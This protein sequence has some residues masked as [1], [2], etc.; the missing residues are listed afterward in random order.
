MRRHG[1]QSPP[2]HHVAT[3]R[4]G[5]KSR[6][7]VLL[8]L[9]CLAVDLACVVVGACRLVFEPRDLWAACR[10]TAGAVSGGLLVRP[11]GGG[12]TSP[13]TL[14]FHAALA[15]EL[16]TRVRRNEAPAAPAEY[17]GPA[18]RRQKA[19]PLPNG[20]REPRRAA[21][22][23]DDMLGGAAA[24]AV[25]TTRGALVGRDVG[26][27]DELPVGWAADLVDYDA[28]GIEAKHGALA[29]DLRE[30][31]SSA[32][33]GATGSF[34]YKDDESDEALSCIPKVYILGAPKAGTSDLWRVLTSHPRSMKASRKET[35]FLTR[36]EFGAPRD[37]YVDQGTRLSEFAQSH[38]A[39]ARKVA[40]ELHGG[41]RSDVAVVD[42]GPHTLWWST[43]R[44][45]GADTG[46]VPAPQLMFHMVPEAKL[47]VS[48]AEPAKRMYSDYWF[49]TAAGVAKMV[50]D[51]KRRKKGRGPPPEI[52]SADDFHGKALEDARAMEL[53]F[54]RHDAAGGGGKFKWDVRAVQR[55][56]YDMKHFAKNGRG[57]IAVSVY[58]AY[59]ARWL[60]AY[61]RDQ[62]LFTRL[63]DRSDAPSMRAEMTRVF[64][65]LDMDPSAM[66]GLDDAALG[67]H[68]NAA[69]SERPAMRDDTAQVLR[70]FFRPHNDRLADL[71]GDP[72]FAW[73]DVAVGGGTG[74]TAEDVLRAQ[75]SMRK[76]R[77]RHQAERA[78]P[79]DA[80]TTTKRDVPADISVLDLVTRSDHDGL[81]DALEAHG[82]ALIAE[83]KVS[84]G[85]ALAS[86]ALILD[87]PMVSLLLGP[88]GVSANATEGREAHG[89]SSLHVACMTGLWGDSMRDSFTFSL[90]GGDPH[91]IDG[92]IRRGGAVAGVKLLKERGTKST[93]GQ[94]HIRQAISNAVTAVVDA[95]LKHGADPS[96]F[97]TQGKT[98]AHYC[99]NSGFGDAIELLAK[100]GANLDLTEKQ[101]GATPLTQAALNGNARAV[102]ALLENGARPQVR[103]GHGHDLFDLA[104]GRGAP[105][106]IMLAE[107]DEPADDGAGRVTDLTEY[108]D[109]VLL[110]RRLSKLLGGLYRDRDGNAAKADGALAPAG[111]PEALPA[112]AAGGWNGPLRSSLSELLWGVGAAPRSDAAIEARLDHCDFDV[113]E[114]GDASIELVLDHLTRNK[115]VILRGVLEG[116]TGAKAT[117]TPSRL[118]EM[119]GEAKVTV[120][121]IPY[122]K[123]FSSVL[124]DSEMTLGEYVDMMEARNL[125]GGRYPWYVFRGHPTSKM[126]KKDVA[127]NVGWF[128]NPDD[129]PTPEVIYKTFENAAAYDTQRGRGGRGGP[130]GG[131]EKRDRM[132]EASESAQRKAW[133][134]R[135]TLKGDDDDAPLPDPA[136]RIWPFVNL[137]WALGV[138]GS[139]APQHF[140]NTA[141]NALVYGA[142]R[143]LVFPPAYSFM[144]NM[145]I[146]QWDETEREENEKGVGQ[147]PP[148]ECIQRAGDVAI[149]PELWG[150]GIIN[151]QDTIAV[152]TEV[153]ASLFR[154]PLPQA[155][156]LVKFHQKDKKGDGEGLRPGRDHHGGEEPPPRRPRQ[157]PEYDAPYEQGAKP[158][159][160]RPQFHPAPREDPYLRKPRGGGDPF[161]DRRKMMRDHQGA[162]EAAR[163][164]RGA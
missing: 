38:E 141:W 65:F 68:A 94:L 44:H 131:R 74:R 78:R 114:A 72:K 110:R 125:T 41:G 71:L 153:K 31:R 87:E 1:Q 99:A 22:G 86:A 77:E 127:H 75:D 36:G 58:S 138:E 97:D 147:P 102:V 133:E 136:A 122:A 159:R 20:F 123:K 16:A 19:R 47:L 82:P 88:G 132:A 6:L 32:K 73:P 85:D 35:R 60:E 130:K 69:A 12:N 152:A 13:A 103:D 5:R 163:A 4:S 105:L 50:N 33:P 43:Q 117:Y 23:A 96:A 29:R 90:L 53:C 118:K 63:E 34:C 3:A 164:M 155:F 84:A 48:L 109:P 156:K 116:W 57:R 89:K 11:G 111:A 101:H 39:T 10:L 28:A 51:P 154:A 126:P 9:V 145:Q 149:I 129:T 64:E 7:P 98:P 62:F 91:V 15:V 151:L 17:E 134:D 135:F 2:R 66:S 95:L 37:G 27:A 92:A 21:P 157:F 121:A 59:V 162:R 161:A 143:W 49:L 158:A 14:A 79:G 24:A 25:A 46:M 128:V 76:D 140:H 70:A 83:G 146:R 80:A 112:L 150:H 104:T 56:A 142:K 45:D 93:Y 54:D 137:Q 61:P 148:L 113:V 67:E 18:L 124:G 144:S 55:C 108:A 52:Q 40:A 106:S 81:R 26:L 119:H 30:A 42:G 160:G 115:P 8:I 100:R 139:G 120:S 107:A